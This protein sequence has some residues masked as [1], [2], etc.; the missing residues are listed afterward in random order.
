MV[1]RVETLERVVIMG[2]MEKMGLDLRGVVGRVER[3]DLQEEEL[4]HHLHLSMD[5]MGRT[6]DLA[7]ME[8]V[9][10]ISAHLLHR[11]TYLLTMVEMVRRVQMEPGE[12]VEVVPQS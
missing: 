2:R 9:E 11:V 3:V 10:P 7:I 5:R 4:P 1:E 6:G 12:V 8:R